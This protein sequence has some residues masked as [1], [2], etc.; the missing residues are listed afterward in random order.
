M[1]LYM[2]SH[3]LNVLMTLYYQF[4]L[5]RLL[6]FI[7]NKVKNKKKTLRTVIEQILKDPVTIY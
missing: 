3:I 5:Q 6:L 4:P 2:H 7:A 1:Y